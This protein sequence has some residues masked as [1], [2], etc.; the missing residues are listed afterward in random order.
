M[1]KKN[2]TIKKKTLVITTLKKITVFINNYIT[3]DNVEG[4]MSCFMLRYI[5]ILYKMKIR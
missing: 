5:K 2:T 4:L 3:D 1:L